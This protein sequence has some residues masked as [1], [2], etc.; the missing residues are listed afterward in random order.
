VPRYRCR[1]QYLI[2]VPEVISNNPSLQEILWNFSR[3]KDKKKRLT[4]KDNPHFYSDLPTSPDVYDDNFIIYPTEDFRHADEFYVLTDKPKPVHIMTDRDSQT[5]GN[6]W[7]PKNAIIFKGWAPCFCFFPWFL[8]S[9]QTSVGG[10]G[11]K[12]SSRHLSEAYTVGS[13]SGSRYPPF[14][15]LPRIVVDCNRL[16]QKV[17][18]GWAGNPRLAVSQ[19]T[20][21]LISAYASVQGEQPPIVRYVATL[22]RILLHLLTLT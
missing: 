9:C 3:F 4:L 2:P 7:C 22:S 16:S 10:S 1:S 13:V 11:E 19:C 14:E 17:A 12:A 5:F 21:L 20:V 18:H 6:F 15:A 8:M